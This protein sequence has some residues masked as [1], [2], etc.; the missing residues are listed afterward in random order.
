MR[1]QGVRAIGATALGCATMLLFGT[2]AAGASVVDKIV[3]KKT[4]AGKAKVCGLVSQAQIA[5]VMGNANTGPQDAG[6]FLGDGSCDYLTEGGPGADVRVV[7][8][9]DTK[10]DAK[11]RFVFA[12][13]AKFDTTYGS[14][15]PVAGV[16]KA[17][18]YHFDGASSV[19]QA[20][21]LVTKG[22]KAVQ[23]VLTGA[24][25]DHDSGLA[26]SK[27]IAALEFKKL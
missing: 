22:K 27:Q 7:V 18:W 19:P 9:S 21:L 23:V 6:S 13:K 2:G 24:G 17:G 16:G 1:R 11:A 26:K 5:A 4:P 3:E 10:R 8:S 15:E 14:D 12:T 25:L 20:A